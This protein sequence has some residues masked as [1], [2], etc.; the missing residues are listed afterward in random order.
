[1]FSVALGGIPLDRILGDARSGQESSDI[2][3]D[4]GSVRFL[5]VC[6]SRRMRIL[7]S[8]LVTFV[9]IQLQFSQILY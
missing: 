9:M 3:I 7:L 6:D 5:K 8:P 4:L 1:M 2:L